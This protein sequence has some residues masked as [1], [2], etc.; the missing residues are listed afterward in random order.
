MNFKFMFSFL[1]CPALVI[2]FKNNSYA[3]GVSVDFTFVPDTTSMI[4]YGPRPN[5]I[6]GCPV[7]S[8]V[9][10]RSVATEFSEYK[11]LLE[12]S[13]MAVGGAN[14][15]KK[16]CRI[17]IPIIHDVSYRLAVTKAEY[18]IVV[19][20]GSD[21]TNV[22]TLADIVT[23]NG[24]MLNGVMSGGTVLPLFQLSKKVNDKGIEGNYSF[25]TGS[26]TD[27][28]YNLYNDEFRIISNNF[29]NIQTNM[30]APL[31]WSPCGPSIN[32]SNFAFDIGFQV[33]GSNT[34]L[35]LGN[36]PPEIDGPQK[37]GEKVGV[38]YT[39]KTQKCPS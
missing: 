1:I 14:Y 28:N 19:R 38:I 25:G 39:F 21:S 34:E 31:A 26:I 7:G 11:L 29:T 33:V 22:Y 9:A 18:R 36:S 5:M 24:N 13:N 23:V 35:D 10:V 4:Y 27:F 17:I 15:P 20:S 37:Y 30:P 2:S 8:V 6:D 12:F 32:R 3:T 16:N